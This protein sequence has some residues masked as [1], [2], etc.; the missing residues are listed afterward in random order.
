MKRSELLFN[1]LSIPVDIISLL[2]AGVTA[3]ILRFKLVDYV[4]QVQFEL[5]L[6]DLIIAMGQALPFLLI[7]F[8]A[9]GLY[10]LR[11]T[12]RFMFELNRIA[13]AC[14]LAVLLVMVLFFFDRTLFPSRFI[15]LATWLLSILFVLAGRML[16][17]FIQSKLFLSGYGLHN[18]VL[19]NGNGFESKIIEKTLRH[20]QHG[21]NIIAE[22]T[23][24]PDIATELDSIF[25]KK[26][27][28]EIIQANPQVDD[29]VNLAIV[30][31]ARNKG[32]QFSFV[33]NLFEV[34]RNAVE[35][36]SIRGIPLISLKNTPLD[37]WGKVAKRLF[38]IAA[39]LTCLFITSPFFL[40]ISL[41][42]KLD[43]KGKVIYG[44]PRG[45]KGKDFQF[46]KFR[47]MYS[48]MSVGEQYGGAEAERIRQE[49]WKANDR[50]GANA[51]FLKIK[52]DPRVTPVGRILRKTKL[53]EI[54]QFWN[55]LKGDMSMVGPRA[56]VIDEVER[57]RNRY[58]RMFS[59]KPGIFGVSQLAQ[60]NWPD[61][62]FEEEIRLNT[63]YI[64]NWSLWWDVKI[65]A[66]TF[67]MLF[68]SRKSE[69]DY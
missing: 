61:L 59:I 33:P 52:S 25:G 62:P 65:L 30:E 49:L 28:D 64:E 19:V 57:Y 8:A 53:D 3:F 55:V 68:F 39:S 48:H 15:I 27:F 43:S 34:Q 35:L 67:H 45:G 13:L 4:G 31:F 51:P 66:K 37:G 26:K 16:L 23:A 22:L 5:G 58:Q 10:N 12:R 60:M 41:A 47:S 17:R 56:H 54:P 44:A 69:E 11:G 7:A 20:R 32:L 40:V 9:L 42:I 46:Y 36:S 6:R 24:G 18:L 29:A 50:G 14:S 1:L 21:Y 38:D 2:A 63:Y